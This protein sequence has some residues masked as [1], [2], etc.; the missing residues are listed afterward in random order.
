MGNGGCKAFIVLTSARLPS[1]SSSASAYRVNLSEGTVWVL[2]SLIDSDAPNSAYTGFNV[3]DGRLEFETVPTVESVDKKLV[4]N[5]AIHATLTLNLKQPKAPENNKCKAVQNVRT[6]DTIQI[7]WHHGTLTDI[8]IGVGEATLYQQTF[9]FSQYLKNYNYI[10]A[11]GVLFFEYQVKPNV[12]DGSTLDSTLLELSGTVD[13]DRAGWVVP[14]VN[15]GTANDLGEADGGY[16]MLQCAEGL[17]G[18]WMVASGGPAV[19]DKSYLV[20]DDERFIFTC[21]QVSAPRA[22]IRQ[23]VNLWRLTGDDDSRRVHF[24]M[25]YKENF[26]LVFI[27]DATQG[28]LLY[29]VGNSDVKLDRPF[30]IN[31]QAIKFDSG[32]GMVLLNA[33][34]AVTNFYA[35]ALRKGLSF[36]GSQSL[37]TEPVSLALRN[38]LLT[39]TAPAMVTVRGDLIADNLMDKGQLKIIFGVYSWQPILPDPYVANFAC[40][41]T[42]KKTTHKVGKITGVTTATV[43]WETPAHPQVSFDGV[44][45]RPG[46][47]KEKP[48]TNFDPVGINHPECPVQLP[49]TQ[50]TQGNISL[51]VKQATN[52]RRQEQRALSGLQKNLNLGVR[53]SE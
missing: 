18:N 49:S 36:S 17:Q 3:S 46:N 37:S 8:K 35:V 30:D 53:G 4:I 15:V 2:T 7:I 21:F 16:W 20:I 13:I 1:S 32:L 11:L 23:P 41:G 39:T 24:D 29:L 48:I 9:L 42:G 31:G 38:A 43:Q 5:H 44:L 51:T 40:K 10:A 28:D 45:G 22:G 47:I 33:K 6:P 34:A 25:H 50:T 52:V 12:W 27:C 26:P 14:V 19:L